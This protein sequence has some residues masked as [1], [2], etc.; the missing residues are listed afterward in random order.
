LHSSPLSG[1]EIINGRR[2]MTPG[3]AL[4]LEKVLGMS[5]SF[6]MDLQLRWHLYHAHAQDRKELESIEPYTSATSH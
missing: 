4:R 1:S 6:W 3:T 2:G 5:S